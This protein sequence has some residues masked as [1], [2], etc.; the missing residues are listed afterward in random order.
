MLR[1]AYGIGEYSQDE[2][3]IFRVRPIHAPR[4]LKLI[5]GEIPEGAELLQI[6]LWNERMP[7]IPAGGA[8]L[9]WGK[10]FRQAMDNGFHHLARQIEQDPAFRNVRAIGGTSLLMTAQR[11]PSTARLW[12]RYGFEL[13]AAP[14]VSWLLNLTDRFYGWLL[15]T[16]FQQVHPSLWEMFRLPRRDSWISRAEF[17]KRYGA[18]ATTAAASPSVLT[19]RASADPSDLR[20]S[21]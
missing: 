14:D 4:A 7:P 9:A 20:T 3:C 2:D 18:G 11:S 21:F 15:L 17:L 13:S 8:N 10:R 19:R 1:A 12:E 16:E 5:D 6:H